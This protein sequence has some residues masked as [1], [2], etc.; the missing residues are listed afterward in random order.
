[1]TKRNATPL[2]VI[3]GILALGLGAVL[4]WLG[5]QSGEVRKT[6]E[7][8]QS[9]IDAPA[10][11]NLVETLSSDALEGREACTDGNIAAR[12]FVRKRFEQLF[13]EPIGPAFEQTFPILEDGE[14]KCQGVNLLGKITGDTEAGPIMVLTAH[15]DHVGVIDEEIHNG[16]DDNASGVAALIAV[17]EYF[18]RNGPNHTIVFAALDAEEMGMVGARAMV[19]SGVVDMERV[20]LN[21]NFD[22]VSRSSAGE[23]YASGTSHT[24]ALI[25]FVETLAA[26]APITLLTGHDTS[27]EDQPYYDWTESSDHVAF[28]EAGI[29]FI[30]FGVEDH[31]DYHAP[32]DDYER[33]TPDFFVGSVE[34]LVMAAKKFDE[35]LAV[36]AALR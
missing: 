33:I 7:T 10:M 28:H 35:N 31:E 9:L 8:T 3:L 4:I 16:A 18:T 34:T 12:G 2:I 32:G 19:R 26:Q 23:L 27:S 11:L 5:R 14:L 29:P 30:Y 6:A 36:I 24:P 21:L 20:A 15:Y 17:A 25:P 1:M 22:M 13:L